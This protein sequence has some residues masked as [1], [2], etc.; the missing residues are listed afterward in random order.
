MDS[1]PEPL[2]DDL[3]Q[4]RWL[5]LVG[6][7]FSRNAEYESGPAPAD[8]RELGAALGRALHETDGDS[9]PIESIS[10]F[11]QAFGRVALVDR[12]S[13]LV[14]THDAQPGA[15]H[16][17]FARVAFR[18]VITTNFDFLLE[19]AYD[20]AGRGCLPVL[21]EVQ[22]S[23]PNRAVGPRVIKLH[24]DL[25]HPSRLVLTEDDYDSFLHRFP[26]LA[27]SVSALLIEHTGVLIGYSL[28]D[29]DTRQLLALLKLRLGTMRRPLW[30]ILF[31]ANPSTVTRFERR[32]VKVVNLRRARGRSLGDLYAQL[33]DEL[34][35]H[36]RRRVTTNTE[37]ADDRVSADLQLPMM[38]GR[39]CYFA[40]PTRLIGWYRENIF[41][42]VEASG[43][44]PVTARDVYSPPGSV[45][46]KI[47]ALI[48]RAAAVVA[49]VG[50][51]DV[52]AYEATRALTTK[53]AGRTLIVGSADSAERPRQSRDTSFRLM[54]MDY[55]LVTRPALDDD[56]SNFI[57]SIHVWLRD[58]PRD[59]IENAEEPRRLLAIGEYGPA[60]VSAVSLL[61]VSLGRRLG[62]L[63]P[64]YPRT[65]LRGLTQAAREVGLIETDDEM[66]K[67]ERALTRRNEIIH[68]VKPI[69]AA[70]ARRDVDLILRVVERARTR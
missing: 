13:E 48:E 63:V 40:V 62:E 18:N 26:L 67:I 45:G 70:T 27:T 29:A 39:L 38:D 59:R 2:V 44:V 10:A 58:L 14:R 16:L 25:N 3:V 1:L 8:W 61:E 60:L 34:A 51:D 21:D 43:L 64:G 53:G 17:A 20:R 65:T 19:R 28:D 4:G 42:V 54:P 37:S 7:G 57:Q 31:G 36:W 11:E 47:D 56:P 30:T 12:V 23:A 33:F 52:G 69:D 55:T 9:S 22:L 46:A 68:R 6:A 24:G 32:G 50:P 5:P 41:P 49:E 15:A 35:T 66:D